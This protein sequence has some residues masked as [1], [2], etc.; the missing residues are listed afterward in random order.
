MLAK[1]EEIMNLEK[2]KKYTS[3]AESDSLTNALY[4][5][6][7]KSESLSKIA[8]HFLI[9]K[10]TNRNRNVEVWLEEFSRQCVR[11]DKNR[12]VQIVFRFV[13]VGLVYRDAKE[14]WNRCT[15]D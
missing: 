15:V 11:F 9:K 6:A 4:S 8:K 2:I 13:N 12:N 3:V 1:C 10:F 7:N 14:N 5:L